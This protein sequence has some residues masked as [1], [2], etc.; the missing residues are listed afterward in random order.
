MRSRKTGAAVRRIEVIWRMEG[1]AGVQLA[2]ALAQIGLALNGGFR[3]ATGVA[4]T[5]LRKSLETDMLRPE[6]NSGAV[7]GRLQPDA[8]DFRFVLARWRKAQIQSGNSTRHVQDAMNWLTKHGAAFSWSRYQDVLPEHCRAIFDDMMTKGREPRTHNTRRS[9]LNSFLKYWRAEL[10]AADP[11]LKPADPIQ[12]I[13]TSRVLEKDARYTPTEEEVIKLIESTKQRQRQKR[14]R[15]LVY[16]V[17]ATTGI[18]HGVCKR[19]RWEHVF[20]SANPP[21]LKL[22]P[23]IMKNRRK[24]TIWLPRE[25]AQALADL[26]ATRKPIEGDAVFESV[27]K[28]H[29]FEADLR[30]AEIEKDRGDLGKFCFHSLRHFSSNRMEW[31]KPFTARERQAQN[32]HETEEMTKNIYTRP[33]HIELGRKVASMPGL[34]QDKSRAQP[35]PNRPGTTTEDADFGDVDLILSALHAEN[36]GG[37]HE[38]TFTKSSGHAKAKSPGLRGRQNSDGSGH[39]LRDRVFSGRIDGQRGLKNRVAGSNPVALIL[40]PVRVVRVVERLLDLLELALASV[41]PEGSD[42]DEDYFDGTGGRVGGGSG[43]GMGGAVA[44]GGGGSGGSGGGELA[45]AAELR[46]AHPDR[47]LDAGASGSERRF[48]AQVRNGRRSGKRA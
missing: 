43:D 11:L 15:W 13:P 41:G 47:G 34:L 20:E 31:Q 37:D 29:S 14:D 5:P 8:A 39:P 38:G 9:Y 40:S 3:H 10:C 4:P 44:P 25:T 35:P 12:M 23:W 42:R 18:R 24:A 27:P 22:P 7:V 32:S 16:L 36:S 26:R 21:Y 1:S 30:A 33:D 17:A 28:S 46:A 19:I 2:R 6:E 48:P 45:S